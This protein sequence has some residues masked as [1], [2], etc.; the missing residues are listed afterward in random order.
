MDSGTQAPA[1]KGHGTNWADGWSGLA[2]IGGAR[3][4]VAQFG[5]AP[6]ADGPPVI[7]LLHEGLGCVDLWR[8][9]PGQLAA[10]TR[11]PVLA[12]SRRGYG[13]SDLAEL[14]RPLDYMRREAETSLPALLAWLDPAEFLLVGHSDG[15][16]IAALYAGLAD[17]GRLVGTVLIAPH[18]FTEPAG[19][20]SIADARTAYETTDLRDRLAKYHRDPDNCFWGWNNAWLDPDFTKFNIE[21][22]L[23]GIHTPVQFIQGAADQYGSLAQLEAIRRHCPAPLSEAVLADCKHSPHIEKPDELTGLI[24]RFHQDCQR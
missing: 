15:A 8:D 21:Y 13:R 17:D 16:S 12:Y 20:A 4:E 23:S 11:A 5:P 2:D 3:L 10:A 1:R 19:L 14:P 6:A 22:C 9:F 18:F 24:A 7:I